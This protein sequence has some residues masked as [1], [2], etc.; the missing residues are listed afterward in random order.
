M[1][2]LW[3]DLNAG[4]D[5]EYTVGYGVHSEKDGVLPFIGLTLCLGGRGLRVAAPDGPVDWMNCSC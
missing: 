2:T 5:M 3:L 4:L 1:F